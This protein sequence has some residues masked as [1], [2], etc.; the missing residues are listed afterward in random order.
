V[1]GFPNFGI[2]F[3]PNAFPAHNSVIYTN[4]VQVEY[5]IKALFKPLLKGSFSVLDVKEAAEH[6]DATEVQ[7]KLKSM[8]WNSGCSNWNLDASGR[9]TTNYHDETWKFWYRLWWPVWDDF[10]LSGGAGASL[11]WRP[12]WK[13][14]GTALAICAASMTTYLSVM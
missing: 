9:N 8:V 6:R 4:E 1:S 13:I 2:I 11:P 12:E 14:L 5:V 3:G 10:D 7:T